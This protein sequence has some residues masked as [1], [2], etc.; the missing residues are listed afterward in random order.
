[1]LALGIANEPA[2]AR[3][4]VPPPDGPSRPAPG[5]ESSRPAP[6]LDSPARQPG[7]APLLDRSAPPPGSQVNPSLVYRFIESYGPP[8]APGQD[9][10]PFRVAF[11]ETL[12][13]QRELPGAAP[14]RITLGAGSST[15][16]GRPWS[17]AWT[18]TRCP[19]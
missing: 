15:P 2:S 6:G 16:P 9:I 7:A 13:Q 19:P 1:M 11:A 18:T 8:E 4:A 17:A 14:E 3:Q 12:E 5:L 10:G